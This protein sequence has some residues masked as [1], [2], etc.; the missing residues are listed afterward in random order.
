MGA[1]QHETTLNPEAI[2][3]IIGDISK[4]RPM[5]PLDVIH[6]TPSALYHGLDRYHERV[7][8]LKNK[9]IDTSAKYALKDVLKKVEKFETA[10]DSNSVDK[11]GRKRAVED[12]FGKHVDVINELGKR[13]KRETKGEEDVAE[14]DDGAESQELGT[15]TID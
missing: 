15:L 7:A 9:M 10:I 11:E 2:N 8:D 4:V 1:A 14:A 13:L 6:V 12:A 5:Q 3:D